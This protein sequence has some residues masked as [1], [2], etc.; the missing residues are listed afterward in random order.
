MSI[1]RFKYKNG[2][3]GYKAVVQISPTRQVAKRF[4]RGVDAEIWEKDQKDR[5]KAGLSPE[6]KPSMTVKDLADLWLQSHA[7]LRLEGSTYE[8]YQSYLR[9]QILPEFGRT[10]VADLRPLAVT[11]WLLRLRDKA[12]LSEKTCNGCLGLFR[13]IL[14]DAVSWKVL[15]GNPLVGVSRLKVQDSEFRFWTQAECSTF[16]EHVHDARPDLYPAYVVALNTGMRLGEMTGLR[17]DCVDLERRQVTV[18]RAWCQQ[19]KRLKEMT[20]TKTVRVIPI[21]QAL[22]DLLVDLRRQDYEGFV[23]P[24]IDFKNL[25]RSTK[26]LAKAAGVRP[27]RAHDLRHSFAS[28][29]MMAGQSMFELQKVLGH[30]SIQMT[31]RYSHLAPDHLA[32]KTEFLNLAARKPADVVQLRARS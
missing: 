19:E 26:T 23:L 7:K 20:K 25:H 10:R 11:Q 9:L 8:R 12:G 31:E 32:G 30:Q 14:N 16:L 6:S 1:H 21:N 27:I 2:A 17:W 5:L 29:W 3:V 13:K 18:K 24:R 15:A 28:M 22:A 4:R